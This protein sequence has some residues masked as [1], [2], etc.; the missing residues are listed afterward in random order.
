MYSKEE[1]L[2]QAEQLSD[3]I[4]NLEIVKNYQNIEQQI[5]E[6][7]TIKTKMNQLKKQQKQS[8]NFQNYGK[9][10]A[11][12]QSEDTIYNLENEINE[13]PIVEEFRSAQYETNDF[14]QMMI[15]TM[16]KRLNDYN[17]KEHNDL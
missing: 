15:S 3:K 14:L 4:S 11:Y 5:H 8:V 10:Y 12:E 2:K 7:N 1:I 17:K 16:E 13:L 6:N 9:K